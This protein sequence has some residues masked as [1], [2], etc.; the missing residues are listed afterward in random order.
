[1]RRNGITILCLVLLVGIINHSSAEEA[2]QI[3]CTGKVVD[4]QGRPIAG[5][6][7]ALHEMVYGQTAYSY[8]TKLIEE[9]TTRADGVFSF[10]I[11][12]ESDAYRYGYIVADKEGLALGFANWRMREGDKELE[13]QLGQPKELAGLVVDENDKP[14]SGAHVSISILFIGTM[15]EERGVSGPIAAELF[16]STTDAAGKFK[17]TKISPKATAEFIMKKDGRATVGTFKNTGMAD[18]KLNFAAGQADIKLVLPIESKIEGIVVQKDTGKP[19]SG[20][21]LRA[22]IERGSPFLRQ[23]PLVSKQDGT[24]SVTSLA[25]DRYLL[26]VVPSRE[27]LGDWIAES[28]EVIA[29]AGKTVSEVKIELSKGGILEVVITDAVNKK[30]V[31]KVSVGV[32]NQASSQ[33]YNG[34]SDTDGIAR[35]RLIPGE[36]QLSNVYKEGY[37]RQRIQDTVTIEEDKTERL[38]YELAGMSKV[39]GV[40]RDEKGKPLEGVKVKVCPTGRQDSVSQAD[41]TFEADYDPGSWSSESPGFILVCR[42]KEGNLAAAVP[43]DEDIRELNVTLKSAVTLTG[44]VLDP[45]GKAIANA[46]VNTMIKGPRWGSTIGSRDPTMTDEE[47]KFEIMAIPAENKY[48]FYTLAEGYG[49]N[50]REEINTEDA[51]NNH[52]D[53]G[54]ITL[55][56]ANLSVSG[57]VVDDDDKPVAGAQVS[58]YGDNQPNRRAQTD[59]EGKFTLEKVCAGKIRIS[60]DK[61]GTPRLYGSIE[62]EGGATEVNIVISQRSSSTRYQPKRPRSLVG[63]PLPELKDLKVNLSPIKFVNKMILVCFWD[64][65]QRP[66]RNCIVRLNRE[67]Q[68]L[69]SKGVTVVAVQASKIDENTLNQWVK[70]FNIK[71]TVGMIQ[72]DAE[73]SRFAWGVRSLPWLILTDKQHTVQ[74]QGFSIN[75]LNER[76]A[77]LKEK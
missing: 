52:L 22:R 18:Q 37:S 49:E 9:V 48:S 13:I 28:V 41:G 74:M 42:Y 70:R 34:R 75:E 5:A 67:A 50:R 71:L 33:Y 4:D 69:K 57:M 40:V 60:A 47:G 61:S 59:M 72:G 12:A 39:T 64:M 63:R 36:Y 1:M 16:T 43:M 68:Q 25:A 55:A 46:R 51:V 45:D 11:N 44:K 73:K 21:E 2:K 54:T 35:I 56:V 19:V 65:E 53:V 3:T 29:E 32:R 24:F 10:S 66:S 7:V 76:I 27:G 58:C 17:F 8:E 15:Q 26:E 38:E 30:P 20:V 31:E 62:T 14:L 77:T 6:K 23:E